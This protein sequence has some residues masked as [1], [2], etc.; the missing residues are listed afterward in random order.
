MRE[1][2][3][4]CVLVAAISI[5]VAINSQ[6]LQGHIVRSI[7]TSLMLIFSLMAIRICFI[8]AVEELKKK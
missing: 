4:I 6:M 1:I 7:S 5:G 3:Y 8:E 2:F